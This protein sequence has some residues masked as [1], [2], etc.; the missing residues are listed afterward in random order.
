ML[1]QGGMRRTTYA[2]RL[3]VHN[4]APAPRHVVIRDHLPVSQHER[5]KVKVLSIQP[6]PGERTKLELM[7]WQFTL[8]SDSE[9]QIEYRFVVEQPQDLTVTGLV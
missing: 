3:V 4:Y 7:V 9:Q 2:Y 5:V 1:L 8:A 6:P